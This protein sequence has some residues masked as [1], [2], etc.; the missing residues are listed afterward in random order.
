MVSLGP[1]GVECMV[2]EHPALLFYLTG[3]SLRGISAESG[4][5]GVP[6]VKNN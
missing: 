4:A 5:Q 3:N 1:K 6:C 2:L